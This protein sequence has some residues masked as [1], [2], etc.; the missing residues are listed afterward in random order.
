[1]EK[2]KHTILVIDDN[3][4]FTETVTNSLALEGYEVCAAYTVREAL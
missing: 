4:S 3:K 1:M 2:S